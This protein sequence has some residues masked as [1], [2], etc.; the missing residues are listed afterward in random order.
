MDSTLTNADK[1]LLAAM[2]LCEGDSARTFTAEALAVAAWLGDKTS[3]GL[4]G[5]EDQYP[6]SNKLFKSIDSKG[7]LVVKGLI[8]KVGDRTFRLSAGGIAAGSRL[9]PLSPEKQLRLERELATAVSRLIEHAVFREWIGDHA[10]P[11][12]FSAAGQFWGVA[13]GTPERIVRGRINSIQTTLEE[14]LQYMTARGVDVL[15]KEK[16]KPL[17]DRVDVERC[18][19]FH[20]ALKGRFSKELAILMPREQTGR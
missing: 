4:R 5:Y 12:K 8:Q 1:V 11:T 3:F 9:D 15:F 14:A 20:E 17:C 18:L 6:D 19:E 13:P 2:R 10:K 16:D 7:G